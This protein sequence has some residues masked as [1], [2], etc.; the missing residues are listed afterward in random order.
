MEALLHEDSCQLQAEIAESLGVN[1]TT[2]FKCLKTLEMI[3]KQG[4]WGLYEA[5]RCQIAFYH[6]WTAASIAEKE[7]FFASYHDWQWKVDILW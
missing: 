2:V 6:V 3:Q 5:E 4:H 7:T 1:H